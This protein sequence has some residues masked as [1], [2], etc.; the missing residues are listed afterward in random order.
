M[1]KHSKL[2]SDL[3]KITKN[4]EN[5]IL[6][7]S[8]GKDSTLLLLSFIKGLE[9]NVPVLVFSHFWTKRQKEFIGDLIEKYGITAFFF[10]PE[11]LD[12]VSPYVVAYYRIGTKLMPILF[13]HIQNHRCGL[14]I[15]RRAMQGVV[16][17]YIWDTT[18]TGSKKQDTHPL[19]KNLDFSEFE[20]DTDLVTP[21]WEW[22]D[23][24]VI[25]LTKKLGYD[26]NELAYSDDSYDTGNFI[27]CMNCQCKGQVFCPKLNSMIDGVL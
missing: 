25:S 16:P 2:L 19:V 22:S 3:Y 17:M 20:S 12:F 21:L 11:R 6:C 1:K 8:G 24:E 18:I 9:Y 26:Y 27:A 13:D 4:S 23:D 10:R 14:D 5:P 7:W 15:G